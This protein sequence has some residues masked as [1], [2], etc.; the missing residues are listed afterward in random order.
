MSSCVLCSAAPT[1]GAS[2]TNPTEGIE[3]NDVPLTC[4]FAMGIQPV[5]E[6]FWKFTAKG[7]AQQ[8][9]AGRDSN[10][11]GSTINT[12]LL[13]NIQRNDAGTY[14]CYVRNEF[15]S[16]SASAVVTVSCEY[17]CLYF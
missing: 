15:G 14:T 16:V 7:T 13:S 4:S 12:L 3:G 5:G 10:T 17:Y 11:T 1:I 8:I 9:D 6:I 2:P